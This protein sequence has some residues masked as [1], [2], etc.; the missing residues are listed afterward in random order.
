MGDS[1]GFDAVVVPV[2]RG[3]RQGE[4]GERPQRATQDEASSSG[5]ENVERGNWASKSEYMLSMIGNAVGLGNLW[6]F[7]YLA[8]K[9]GGGAFLIPYIIML[10]FVG[11][12]L[13][14]L[15]C[16]IGQFASLGPI[17]IWK[18]VPLLK[19]LGWMM[20]ITSSLIA[21]YYNSIIAY[22]LFYLFAS[23]TSELPWSSCK[24]WWGADENCFDRSVCNSSL[25]EGNCSSVNSSKQTPSE[26]YWNKYA[27]RRSE[28]MDETGDVVWHLALTLLLSW[29]VT[30]AALVKGIKSSGKVVYFTAIFP[31]VVLIILL[32][33]G[34]TLPGAILGIEYY[35]G[36]QS[37][38]TKLQSAEVWKDAAT[39]IVFSL[40]TASGCLIALT[41]YNKFHNNCF[42]DALVV[43]ITNCSTSVFAGFV[44]F[45]VLGHMAH[46]TGQP[47][48]EVAD[49]GFGLA[50]VAY[51]EALA[52]LPISPLWS[53]LFFLMF[54]TLG[55]DSQFATIETVTTG[56]V[57]EF[58]NFF[59]KRRLPLLFS[60]CMLLFL[61]GLTTTTQTGIYWVNLVDHFC[62]GWGLLV[63]AAL[64]LIGINWIYGGNRFIRDIE[65]MIGKKSQL[66]WIWW[67]ACWFVISPLLLI[68]IFLWS[69]ITFQAPTYGDVV[70]PMW[71]I[72]LGWCMIIFSLIWIPIIGVWK[73][74]KAEGGSI[75]ERFQAVC[76]PEADWGPYLAQ[77][78]TGRYAHLAS[79]QGPPDKDTT[80]GF[81]TGSSHPGPVAES[82]KEARYTTAL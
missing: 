4:S 51:P 13:F 72:A 47:V 81:S 39:Q 79:S 49:A 3:S 48:S 42:K 15:E 21:L 73:I 14:F 16:S 62:G 53:I 45:S 68:A 38:F 19:G 26:Q 61:L 37:N 74:I 65:M 82:P 63:A 27:L 22:G 43:T 23:F 11:L 54:L 17:T 78:R 6:R 30:C 34:A 67:R 33:R 12:P 71:A 36:R 31:Y 29:I 44:I 50:F 55:L 64:E 24:K 76:R 77:H 59:R 69:I 60:V 28:S 10:A 80:N 20:V 35:I 46:T 75:W 58:P 8:Y 7:P 57:D 66:F 32:I 52:Q 25:A 2:K 40:A 1:G 9:N 41:S 18:V 70:Y 5:D 56:L